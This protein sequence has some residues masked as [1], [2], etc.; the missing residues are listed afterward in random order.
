M[1]HIDESCDRCRNYI[2]VEEHNKEWPICVDGEYIC[3]SCYGDEA[4]CCRCGDLLCGTVDVSTC[5][6][7]REGE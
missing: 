4:Y 5:D 3:P 6:S 2:S 7:C 1:D